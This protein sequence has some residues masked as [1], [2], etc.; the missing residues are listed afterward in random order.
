MVSTS[1]S[2]GLFL[3]KRLE[4]SAGLRLVTSQSWI[5]SPPA[6]LSPSQR[7]IDA[8]LG[9][10]GF[11]RS[12]LY[13]EGYVYFNQAARLI[14]GDAQPANLLLDTEGNIR[15]I[16]LVI[17]IPTEKFLRLLSAAGALQAS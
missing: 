6:K 8:F 11:I 1:R 14:I 12:R 2:I 16:D 4:H 7:E 9:E 3:R 13:P 15:P 17:A 5:A 10:F